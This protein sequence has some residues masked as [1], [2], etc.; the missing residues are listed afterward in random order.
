MPRLD[1]SRVLLDPKF[2]TRNLA[3]IRQTQTVG[4]DGLAVD[5]QKSF[6]F[7]GVVTASSGTSLNRGPDGSH[8]ENTITI[9]TRFRLQD[10]IAG[11]DADLVQYE[12]KQFTVINVADYSEYGRGFIC[13]TCALIP[14]S[15]GNQ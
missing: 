14:L 13:A 2:V 5:E 1:V 3:C 4:D 11:R 6:T 12:G 10:G 8:I 9:H 7:A 15:G